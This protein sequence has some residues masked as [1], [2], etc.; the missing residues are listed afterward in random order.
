MTI[1][2]GAKILQ[3]G[4]VV[5]GP[6]IAAGPLPRA[7]EQSLAYRHALLPEEIEVFRIGKYTLAYIVKPESTEGM[8]LQQRNGR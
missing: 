4:V 5:E 1:A 7:I 3:P 8:A 2:P 6:L